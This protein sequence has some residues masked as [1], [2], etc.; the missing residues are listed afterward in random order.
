MSH[1]ASE[2]PEINQRDLK[3]RASEIMDAIERGESFT[4]TRN[5]HQIATVTPISRR[6]TFVPKERFLAAFAGAPRIDDRKFAE[7]VRAAFEGDDYDVFERA[8]RNTK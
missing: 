3:N 8:R 7:E 4:L 5:G 1:A 6:R 2:P